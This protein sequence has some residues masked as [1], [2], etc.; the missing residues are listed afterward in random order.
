MDKRPRHGMIFLYIRKFINKF[1]LPA[2]NVCVL[3]IM[4]FLLQIK[5]APSFSSLYISGTPNKKRNNKQNKK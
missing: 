3:N 1:S 5:Q 4:V 2:C